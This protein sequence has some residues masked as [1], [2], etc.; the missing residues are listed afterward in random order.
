[1]IEHFVQ[2]YEDDAFLVTQ[3]T[4][5]LR[6]GLSAGDVVI[7]VATKPHRDDFERRLRVDVARAAIQRPGAEHYV[8]L[9]AADTL[10]KIT[11]DGQPDEARFTELIQPILKRAT[12]RGNGRV[13]IFGEM[14]GLLSENEEHEAAIRLEEI[15]NN[16]AKAH[17]F[18][19]FCAYPMRAFPREEDGAPFLRICNGH[20]RVGPT[21]SYTPPANAHEHFR[22]IAT[23]QQKAYALK[24]E[25]EHDNYY[26][27]S[28]QRRE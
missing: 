26:F 16:L 19:L 15:W 4:S 7:V 2:F 12:D 21:E 28:L 8:A 27:E 1:M 6:P 3:V 17:S 11:V 23:S 14:V 24:T 13:R 25:V 10:S 20:S 5:F 22:F 18:S 9:D